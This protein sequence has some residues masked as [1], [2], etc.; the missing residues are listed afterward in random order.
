L[1]YQYNLLKSY[2]LGRQDCGKKITLPVIQIKAC[3][4]ECIFNAAVAEI[5][6]SAEV[7]W[8]AMPFHGGVRHHECLGG[9]FGTDRPLFL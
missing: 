8:R 6:G 4:R 2:E 9:R 5:S 7:L 1:E 3:A